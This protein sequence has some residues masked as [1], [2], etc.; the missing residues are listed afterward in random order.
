MTGNFKAKLELGR[1][2]GIGGGREM[3]G[4]NEFRV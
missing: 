1:E 2:R 3:S 4:F